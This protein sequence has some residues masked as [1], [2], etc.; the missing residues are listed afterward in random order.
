[1]K[2]SVALIRGDA[3]NVYSVFPDRP[4]Q[5]LPEPRCGVDSDPWL[6][7]PGSAA[8][9][10]SAPAFQSREWHLSFFLN[11][12]LALPPALAVFL[13]FFFYLFS[14]HRA[15]WPPVL[16]GKHFEYTPLSRSVPSST[17]GCSPGRPLLSPPPP[18][19]SADAKY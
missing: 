11:P 15:P 3:I 5:H 8:A 13:L 14:P 16:K 2:Q 19:R 9:V 17:R 7:R 10:G 4:R 12:S 18:L 6:A 1:M